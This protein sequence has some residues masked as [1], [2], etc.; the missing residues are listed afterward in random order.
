[1]PKKLNSSNPRPQFKKLGENAQ[2]VFKNQ[3]SCDAKESYKIW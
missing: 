1:M 3:N 2:I